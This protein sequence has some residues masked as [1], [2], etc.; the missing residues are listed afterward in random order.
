VRRVKLTVLMVADCPHAPVLEQRLAE[1]LGART[2]ALITRR[3]IADPDE[4][5]AAGMHGSPTVLV[6]G[7]DPFALPGQPA[8]LSCRLYDNGSGLREGAPSVARLRQ[9]ISRAAGLRLR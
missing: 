7:T 9:A 3:V 2:D 6:D 1:A 4:A 8:S 5:A